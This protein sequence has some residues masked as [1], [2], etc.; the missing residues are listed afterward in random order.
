MAALAAFGRSFVIESEGRPV[1]AYVI[2]LAGREAFVVAAAGA[3]HVCLCDLLDDVITA[4][5]GG[6]DSIA[7]KTRR[8]GLIRRALARGYRVAERLENGTIM[9]KELK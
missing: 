9:R 4:Q 8:R 3:A 1:C 5:A 7:F 6:L 2:E